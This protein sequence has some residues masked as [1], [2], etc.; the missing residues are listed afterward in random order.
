MHV[1]LRA[2]G[3]RGEA[4]AERGGGAAKGHA[5]RLVQLLGGQATPT[6]VGWQACSVAMW[7]L[8]SRSVPCEAEG[9]PSSQSHNYS[10]SRWLISS[11]TPHHTT[12]APRICHPTLRPSQMESSST[13]V[14]EELLCFARLARAARAGP[15]GVSLTLTAREAGAAAATDGSDPEPDATG[16]GA[17]GRDG[18]GGGGV[19]AAEVA[20]E[21]AEAQPA[22]E[23]GE[24][25]EAGSTAWEAEAGG[26]GS[27]EAEAEGVRG[28]RSGSPS[29]TERAGKARLQEMPSQEDAWRIRWG[30]WLWHTACPWSLV[31][32]AGSPMAGPLWN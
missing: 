30:S 29:V 20:A 9:W 12:H 24:R 17:A 21:P 1:A 18:R 19:G 26:G 25:V 28:R 2:V 10:L 31:G 5:F 16:A 32:R 27:G 7:R 14:E 22:G 8:L 11:L 6:Q 15:G 3:T 23:R 13:G 4:S